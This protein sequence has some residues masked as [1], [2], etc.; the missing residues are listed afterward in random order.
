M[1]SN[2]RHRLLQP[3]ASPLLFQRVRKEKISHPAACVEHIFCFEPASLGLVNAETHTLQVVDTMS[4]AVNGNLYSEFSRS[5]HLDVTEVKAV[6]LRIQLY[7][8]I[9][10]LGRLKHGFKVCR[11]RAALMNPS[12][13]RMGED[14]N[15]GWI[16]W[17]ASASLKR[18]ECWVDSVIA[19]RMFSAVFC[20][21]PRT[22]ST[23][24][25]SSAAR[26]PN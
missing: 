8:H 22:C 4:I 15:G 10:F 21:K 7:G 20:P 26:R 23:S 16:S 2:A 5:M 9:V 1:P 17:S 3:L 14:I 24:P 25:E 13:R 12:C 11:N 19:R 6:K 18:W